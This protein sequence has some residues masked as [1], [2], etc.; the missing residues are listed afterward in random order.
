MF[1][2]IFCNQFHAFI[3]NNIE[4]V[5]FFIFVVLFFVFCY[6]CNWYC[7]CICSLYFSVFINRFSTIRM[8]YLKA[9]ANET[10]CMGLRNFMP[11]KNKRLQFGY[12]ACQLFS[13]FRNKKCSNILFNEQISAAKLGIRLCLSVELIVTMIFWYG[14]DV[15]IKRHINVESNS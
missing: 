2:P 4:P 6:C 3:F 5:L 8:L 10:N 7:C 12:T 1:P 13:F 9:I 11:F 15:Q 14:F